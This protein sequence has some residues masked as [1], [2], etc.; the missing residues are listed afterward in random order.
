[1]SVA[2]AV[3]APTGAASAQEAG[4]WNGDRVL[5]LLERGRARRRSTVVDSAF[6]SYEAQARGYVYFFIDRP[7]SEE[8]TLVKADQIALEVFWHA[9]NFTKQRIVGLRDEKVLPT[10]I[11]YHL[12]HLTVVQ[13]DFGD[14]IRMGD[15]D[16]VEE[17]LHPLGPASE[18]VYDFQLADSL[19]VRYGGGG[20]EVRVYEV[21]V[22]PK[23]F[24]E[25]GLIGSVYLDRASAAIVRMSFTF[26]PASYVD[27]YLDY[28]R[29]SLDNSLW[30]GKYWL[31]Y[32]QEAEIRREMPA[33]DFLAGSIIR[34][35]FEID[36]YEFNPDLPVALFT[37]RGVSAVP[38]LFDDLEEEGLA[39]TPGL[40]E[41]RAQA[42]EIVGNRYLTGLSPLRLHLGAVSEGIRYDRAEGLFLG[43]G[44]HVRPGSDAVVRASAGYAFG[45]DQASL[46]FS[47]TSERGTVAPTLEAYWHA[48]RDIGAHPGA[49]PFISSLSTAFGLE[50]HL[51]PYFVQGVSLDL[52]PRT[53]GDGPTITL[54]FERHS[55]ATDVVSTVPGVDFRPV[56]PVDEGIMGAIAA[57]MPLPVP[58][59]GQ[60]RIQGS[61]A[62]L[63][64]R[65]FQ[66]VHTSATWSRESEGE[67]WNLSV[68]LAGGAAT[69]DAPAQALYLLGGRGTLPGYGFREF[70]GTRYGLLR[71]EGSSPLV[72][73]W[74]GLRAFAAV[75]V[76]RLPSSS[77][78]A[79]WSAHD[80]D[81]LRPSV[82]VG[83]SFGWDVLRL[84]LARGLRD[85][86]WE[87]IFAVDPRFHSWL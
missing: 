60:G 16:E 36:S 77:S 1:V 2:L 61:V 67:D 17:V 13:D 18:T 31:P 14:H 56:R 62:R 50:D 76:T 4:A 86:G 8:R 81:G 28:I 21:L 30:E 75:G 49:A 52:A 38:G 66:S 11:Q 27:S 80:S 87:L 70:S 7:D 23:D 33:L 37:G 73:P 63:E 9:P 82:G 64:T 46:G 68:S 5:A 26:T 45:S 10:S 15:G 29:I 48:M 19:T 44:L 59:G 58:W 65:S 57:E 84:D 51:D 35:R 47:T 12:D 22:R 83:L 34:G 25:P 55:S 20:D 42:L 24:D 74:L 43:A 53:E 39:P 3:G 6:R 78:P 54:R 40:Q 69:A 85:G 41:V 72:Y 71:A 32:R 79:G